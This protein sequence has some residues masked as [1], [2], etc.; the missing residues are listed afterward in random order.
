[1]KARLAQIEVELKFPGLTD[2]QAV[3][4]EQERMVLLSRLALDGTLPSPGI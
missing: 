1:M 2:G 3:A 4:L